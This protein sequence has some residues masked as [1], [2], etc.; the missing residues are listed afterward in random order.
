MAKEDRLWIKEKLPKNIKFKDKTLAKARYLD[1]QIDP[2]EAIGVIAAQSLG[3]P[4]T[5][6][7]MRT[8]HFAGASELNV[9]AGLTRIIE[10]LELCRK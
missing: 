8:F 9:T 3:E 2:G 1:M 6:L 5:Q 10:I 4:G 7:T